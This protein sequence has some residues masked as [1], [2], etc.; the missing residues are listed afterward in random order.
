MHAVK[1]CT[2]ILPGLGGYPDT[3]FLVPISSQGAGTAPAH[4]EWSLF[5]PAWRGSSNCHSFDR[6]ETD[7]QGTGTLLGISS[8]C[9]SSE[10]FPYVSGVI[11]QSHLLQGISPKVGS[12]DVG[13]HP[14]G[15]RDIHMWR[16]GGRHAE[17]ET[18][19]QGCA[20][21]PPSR[22]TMYCCYCSVVYIV[23][24]SSNFDF[25][26]REYRLGT[27]ERREAVSLFRGPCSTPE[28]SKVQLASRLY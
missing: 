10:S 23:G 8:M 3:H 12:R 11:G 13:E 18:R 7:T 19:R 25:G 27:C 16:P 22:S 4:G 20:L 1:H 9:V 26:L 24:Y 14:E 5:R 21:Q 2:F 17:A 28:S 15:C 6:P